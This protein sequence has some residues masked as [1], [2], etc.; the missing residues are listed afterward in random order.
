[1]KMKEWLKFTLALFAVGGGI[2]WVSG[3]IL[4]DEQIGDVVFPVIVNNFP[5][6]M[7]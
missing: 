7:S 4:F 1:M 3:N 2:A 5:D 6:L